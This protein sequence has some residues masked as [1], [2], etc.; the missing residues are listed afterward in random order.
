MLVR[1]SVATFF[2]SGRQ[3]GGNNILTVGAR[4]EPRGL[5][6][7]DFATALSLTS[8]PHYFPHPR[9]SADMDQSASP[10]DITRPGYAGPLRV[11][12]TATNRPLSHLESRIVRAFIERAQERLVHCF[13]HRAALDAQAMSQVALRLQQYISQ[14]QALISPLRRFPPEVLSEI[15][16][17]LTPRYNN[18]VGRDDLPIFLGGICNYW[19]QI[20]LSSPRLW[21]TISF[22]VDE[23]NGKSRCELIKLFNSRSGA[24]LLRVDYEDN[25]DGE[26]TQDAQ[27]CLQELMRSSNRWHTVTLRLPQ[28]AY[29]FLSAIKY[30][31]PE[32][33]LLIVEPTSTIIDDEPLVFPPCDAFAA[34]P[35]LSDMTIGSTDMIFMAPWAALE[36]YIVGWVED[37]RYIQ[38]LGQ[39]TRLVEVD[40][41]FRHGAFPDVTVPAH[42]P[43][44][45]ILSLSGAPL[46]LLN[47]LTTPVL[48]RIEFIGYDHMDTRVYPSDLASL[49]AR[50]NCQIS[51]LVLKGTLD[52]S[53]VDLITCIGLLPA[54]QTLI[55]HTD[56][57]QPSPLTDLFIKALT[58]PTDLNGGAYSLAL[59]LSIVELAGSLEEGCDEE[60]L[61]LMLKSRPRIYCLSVEEIELENTTKAALEQYYAEG[62]LRYYFSETI[63]P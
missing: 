18:D 26:W 34:A 30:N 60:L 35:Q 10:F 37:G 57:E 9:H 14:H 55:I 32:L 59:Q 6:D 42:L 24:C 45:E 2:L 52:I 47:S 49:V 27:C 5:Q 48:E 46:G 61:L 56:I 15:F 8:L 29:G 4:W 23:R 43:C 40:I 50:S 36:R 12:H 21:S 33:Q 19:R 3:V 22:R 39:C 7:N 51:E 28:I 20:A 41:Y 13:D 38:W 17:H 54:I 58:L 44:L 62:G 11:F 1:S 63:E 31:L 25:H 53:D 16:L